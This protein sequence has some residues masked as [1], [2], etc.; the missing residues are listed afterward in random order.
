MI[1]HSAKYI[2]EIIENQHFQDGNHRTIILTFLERMHQDDWI[3]RGHAMLIYIALCKWSLDSIYRA[4]SLKALF[5]KKIVKRKA[6][7]SYAVEKAHEVKSIPILLL[8]IDQLHDELND[9]KTNR[10]S[11]MNKL[12]RLKAKS[13]DLYILFNKKYP[14]FKPK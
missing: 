13:S 9:K 7:M 2:S 10:S 3:F 4:N 6:A 1:E 8:L 11:R 5:R 14:R 12:S